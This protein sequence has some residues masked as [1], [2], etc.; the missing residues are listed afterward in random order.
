MRIRPTHYIIEACWLKS[1]V[2]E[3]SLDGKSWTE[4]DRQ[5]DN[6]DFRLGGT[7]S[8]AISTP[9]ECRFIRL[10]QADNHI[11]NNVRI[12]HVVEFFGTLTE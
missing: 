3:G 1:W 4:I 2:V 7:G 6:E 8:F 11:G 10:T 5:T 12:L 9:A